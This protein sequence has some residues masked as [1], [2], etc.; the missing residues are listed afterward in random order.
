MMAEEEKAQAET[1]TVITH[2]V[3]TAAFLLLGVDIQVL[4]CV[5]SV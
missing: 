1:S 3:S 4:Q 2:D 5:I